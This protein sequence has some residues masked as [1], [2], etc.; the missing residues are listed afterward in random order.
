PTMEVVNESLHGEAYDDKRHSTLFFKE[1]DYVEWGF[2]TARKY[3]PTTKLIINEAPPYIWQE[4][5]KYNRSAYYSQIQRALANGISIDSIGMQYHSFNSAENEEKLANFLYNPKQI[6]DVMDTYSDFNK[7]L[8]ITE[9]TIPAYTGEAEDEQLQAEILTNLYKIWFS[10]PNMEAIIYWNLV[11]GYAYGATP[12]DMSYGEN[13]FR[14]GLLNFDLSPKPAYKALDKLINHEWQTNI[15]T[16]C[17]GSF[18]TKAFYGEYEVSVTVD[19]ITQ[20]KVI[21]IEKG[22]ENKFIFNI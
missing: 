16:V 2:I 12:G 4:G 15:E 21:H 13:Y 18:E 3:L 11:D 6:Y 5:Y 14:G 1:P 10:H 19:G 20:N 17:D 7:P 22:A 9:I 8:Q